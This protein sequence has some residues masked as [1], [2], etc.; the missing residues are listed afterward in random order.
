MPSM[1]L[2]TAKTAAEIDKAYASALKALSSL[3]IK[4]ATKKPDAAKL[5]PFMAKDEKAE[6]K[7]GGDGKQVKLTVEG[8]GFANTLGILATENDPD[9]RIVQLKSLIASKLVDK[10]EGEK[11]I[12]ALQGGPDP[13]VVANIA[14]EEVAAR[15]QLDD[16]GKIAKLYAAVTTYDIAAKLPPVMKDLEAQAAKE[17]SMENIDFIKDVAA[18]KGRA[19][20]M[21][22]FIGDK[23][24][25]QVNLSNP[26]M[27][28]IE[29]GGDFA[30]AV[31][32]IK[33]MVGKDTLKR[34]KTAKT[35]E[36][37]KMMAAATKRIT[38][39]AAMKA[40]LGIRP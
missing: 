27:A 29:K 26:V 19:K 5:G 4:M 17:H 9:R 20:V 7:L 28:R 40:K 1:T 33:A 16:A 32:E 18:N 13:K 23:A 35:E 14:R 8:K 21:A 30:A 25:R 24:P 15:K 31:V 34:M 39:L 37:D 10:A 36:I 3:G 11:E 22:E 6:F 12:K 2:S 38:D